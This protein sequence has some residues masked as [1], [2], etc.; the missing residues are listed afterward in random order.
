VIQGGD[1]YEHAFLSI[2]RSGHH[3]IFERKGAERLPIFEVGRPVDATAI[4]SDMEKVVSDHL[5][6]TLDHELD[7]Y[8]DIRSAA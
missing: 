3:G 1:L 4:F 7:Y 8:F 2:M 5:S 6:Q